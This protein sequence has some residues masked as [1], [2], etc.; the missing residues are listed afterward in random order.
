MNIFESREQALQQLVGRLVSEHCIPKT[1]G[2]N[3]RVLVSEGL[4]IA[5]YIE[6]QIGFI[7][8]TK[9]SDETVNVLHEIREKKLNKNA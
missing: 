5:G 4:H 2:R 3:L 8:A 1:E 6:R 7:E 9:W